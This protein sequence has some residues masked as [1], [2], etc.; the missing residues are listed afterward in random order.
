MIFDEIE[1]RCT[2]S[3]SSESSS[4]RTEKTAFRV[5][6]D[7]QI[8]PRVSIVITNHFCERDGE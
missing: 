5:V 3:T 6:S 2:R 7:S 8:N 4:K 1:C